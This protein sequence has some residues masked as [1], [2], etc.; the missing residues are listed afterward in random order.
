MQKFTRRPTTVGEILKEEFLKPLNMTQSKLAEEIGIHRNTIG[1]IINGTA[2]LSIDNAVKL[3]DFFGNS[4]VF[5]LNIQF[6]VSK[7]DA[8]QREIARS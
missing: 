6:E 1:R 4:S 2:N 5:W 7:W 3:A 8:K